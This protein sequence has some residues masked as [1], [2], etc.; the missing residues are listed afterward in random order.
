MNAKS[1][2]IITSLVA[3][4]SIVV[5]GDDAKKTASDPKRAAEPT[6]RIRLLTKETSL[7]VLPLMCD[8]TQ[9]AVSPDQAHA[10]YPAF[11]NGG[12]RLFKDG[13]VMTTGQAYAQIAFPKFSP[14]GLRLAYHAKLRGGVWTTV[15]DDKESP[16]YD[17][18]LA[19]PAV[20]SPNS[21][22]V[23]YFINRGGSQILVI[24]GKEEHVC[25][26]AYLEN[27]KPSG[28]EAVDDR[29][30][31]FSPD[32]GRFAYVVVAAGRQWVVSNGVAHKKYDS[33][34]PPGPCFSPDGQHLVYGA[35]VSSNT[36]VIVRDGKE[37]SRID[38]PGVRNLVFNCDGS[39]LAYLEVQQA[40]G[41]RIGTGFRMVVD[42]KRQ[43]AYPYGD[44]ES[45]R[46]SPDGK[47][48]MYVAATETLQQLLIVDGKE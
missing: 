23:A 15:V 22:H 12:W 48:F 19:T 5:L 30:L 27:G 9:A 17:M 26:D 40:S 44:P 10:V 29:S 6:L 4:C 37:G 32:G 8:Y 38:A 1:A 2:C 16:T 36:C 18:P 28:K 41:P 47:R 45:F 20:F 46:F 33:I 42:D 3:L 24:D 13:V 7:G 35:R 39:K 34:L 14:N 25:K 11:T 31:T 21:E 43:K